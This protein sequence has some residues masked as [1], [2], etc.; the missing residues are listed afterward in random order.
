MKGGGGRWME[1]EEEREW[2]LGLVY[3]MKTGSLFSLK[4]I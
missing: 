3:K 2:T 4:K 1:W